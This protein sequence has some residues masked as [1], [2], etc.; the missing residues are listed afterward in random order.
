MLK[1][2]GLTSMEYVFS[3]HP[4]EDHPGNDSPADRRSRR[5]MKQEILPEYT[6]IAE[7]YVY[8]K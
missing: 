3:I 4:H 6:E 7:R 2:A 5:I 8:G 1:E